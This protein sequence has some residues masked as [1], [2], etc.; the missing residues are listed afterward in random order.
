MD[1]P[2]GE[3]RLPERLTEEKETCTMFFGCID[4]LLQAGPE[5]LSGDH[6]GTL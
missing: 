1:T 6:Y 4:C 3:A 2:M 5:T